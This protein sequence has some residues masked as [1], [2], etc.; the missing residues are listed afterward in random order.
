MKSKF[1]SKT[2]FNKAINNKFVLY[3]VA[4]VSLLN[5]LCNLMNKEFST[6][7]F[8]YL[9]SMITFFHT[10]NMTVV[11][12]TGL[13]STTL[14]NFL[15]NMFGLKEGLENK[16]ETKEEE[17]E[18]KEE[19]EEEEET[20][21]VTEK[22]TKTKEEIIKE[23]DA[24]NKSA[25]DSADKES[26][27]EKEPSD[28][29]KKPE[30]LK[31][32]GKISNQA[33][34]LLKKIDETNKTSKK[35]GYQNKLKLSPGELTLPNKDQLQKQLGKAD[36]MESAY[37]NLEKV[38][39]NNGIKSMSNATKDLVKQQTELLKGLKEITPAL[40]D[41]LGAMSKVDLGGLTKLFNNDN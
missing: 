18:V 20:E 6:V 17:E 3:L 10:K 7:L 24:I 32:I 30:S 34:D 1:N 41:A 23:L 4:F 37:D 14:L 9:I 8:F 21:E 31:N 29:P 5:I 25:A 39:G 26:P 22:D 27:L 15:G 19:T 12:A 2:M 11:L 16:E 28:V 36:K 35:V 38:I 40:N 13:I 33:K